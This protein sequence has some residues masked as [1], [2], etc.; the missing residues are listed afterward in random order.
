MFLAGD[1]LRIPAVDGLRKSSYLTATGRCVY[2]SEFVQRTVALPTEGT[3]KH[4][5]PDVVDKLLPVSFL[6]HDEKR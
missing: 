4:R 6:I 2:A 1:G 3:S 5:P